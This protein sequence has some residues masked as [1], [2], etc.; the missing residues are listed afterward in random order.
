MD[1]QRVIVRRV[2][3]ESSSASSTS[4]IRRPSSPDAPGSDPSWQA[5]TNA[6]AA[7]HRGEC[8]SGEAQQRCS[9]ALERADRACRRVGEGGHLLDLVV[10]CEAKEVDGVD[11][12]AGR[13]AG[14][15]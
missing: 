3:A 11:A 9:P 1:G 4:T 15:G 8:A 6:S 12:R 7:A 13:D 5:R 14:E 10:E 2:F